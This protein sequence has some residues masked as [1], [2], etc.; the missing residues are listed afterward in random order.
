[1]VEREFPSPLWKLEHCYVKFDWFADPSPEVRYINWLRN[2]YEEIWEKILLSL[3][4]SR[5][6]VQQQSLT[7]CLKLMAEEG[8]APTEPVVDQK[9]Y[10]PMH[11]LK[12]VLM[13][14]LS[15]NRDNT[16]LINR[17][18]EIAAYGDALYYAWKCLPSLTPKTQPTECYI[19]NLMELIY[20]LPL[21]KDK[22]GNSICSFTSNFII[23]IYI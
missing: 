15:A 7:T 12:P 6:A 19:K 2:C 8:K 16:A 17:F 13:K 22:D 14:L 20:V 1:M 5:P 21:P 11:R 4:E 18:Q 3:E 10:F 9:Y 23:Y